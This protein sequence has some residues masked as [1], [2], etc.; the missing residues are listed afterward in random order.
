MTISGGNGGFFLS[1]C[2]DDRNGAEFSLAVAGMVGMARRNPP[3]GLVRVCARSDFPPR[4]HGCDW[5]DVGWFF[6]SRA[7]EG[8]WK[9]DAWDVPVQHNEEERTDDAC[10]GGGMWDATR[11]AAEKEVGR[12]G[13]DPTRDG[14]SDGMVCMS[15]YIGW[16]FVW[17]RGLLLH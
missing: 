12:R 4:F 9:E 7:N 11:D 17:S 5:V 6:V 8:N 14:R 3:A 10:I 2:I 13:S 16:V 15:V 1:E